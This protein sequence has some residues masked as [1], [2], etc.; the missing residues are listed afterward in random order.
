MRRLDLDTARA[1]GRALEE[2]VATGQGDVK[3]LKCEFKG[4]KRL[5]CGDM[6]ILFRGSRSEAIE[7]V[8]VLPR[9]QAYRV[10]EAEL[11]EIETPAELAPV[12]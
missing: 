2:Y 5:R 8:R 6:R 10:R 3:S 7:V 9:D 11:E 1:V 12:A 4:S